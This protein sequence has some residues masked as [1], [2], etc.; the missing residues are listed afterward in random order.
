MERR[1]DIVKV[2]AQKTILQGQRWKNRHHQWHSLST[3]AP[4]RGVISE[5]ARSILQGLKQKQ[6]HSIGTF[7]QENKWNDNNVEI[8]L[9]IL[10]AIRSW[11]NPDMVNVHSA[12]QWKEQI[13]SHKIQGFLTNHIHLHW[14]CSVSTWHISRSNTQNRAREWRDTFEFW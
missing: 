10:Y 11:K 2:V 6:F 3:V 1:K 12:A 4:N 9:I 14:P 13:K 7:Q 8:I 5:P